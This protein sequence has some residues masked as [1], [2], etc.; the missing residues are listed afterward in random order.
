VPTISIEEAGCRDCSLCIEIC[1]TKVLD[2]DASKKIATAARQE[3]C[4]GC[5]SCV[6][7][8]PSGC[9][10]VL[11]H[12]EQRPFHRI[13]TNAAL[14]SRM[15]QKQPVSVQLTGDDYRE[16]L[17]DVRVRLKALGDAVIETMGRGQRAVG[18]TAGTL[19]AAHLPEMYEDTSLSLLLD[20]MKSRFAKTFEF[21]AK[22]V[23]E[24]AEMELCIDQCAFRGVVESQKDTIGSSVLCVLFHEY[25]AGLL[26]S[27]L[28]KNYAVDMLETGSRCTMKLQVR[29]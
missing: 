3:D 17:N 5:T 25:W 8:C 9:L 11:D 6:Y 7:M 22:V 29:G 27:F 24:G 15:L 18:R 21:N 19:A 16:A 20:H 2:R 1:P 23:E 28:G 12:V 14:V 4:I 26:G 10:T 13:E